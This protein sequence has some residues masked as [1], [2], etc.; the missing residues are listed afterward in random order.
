MGC[1][2]PLVKMI[3]NNIPTSSKVSVRCIDDF[4]DSKKENTVIEHFII[5]ITSDSKEWWRF[6]THKF[7]KADARIN[8]IGEK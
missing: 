2:Y 8:L 4:E 5:F 6:D 3:R 7:F 1:Q